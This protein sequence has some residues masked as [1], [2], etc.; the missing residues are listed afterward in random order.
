MIHDR[1]APLLC[2]VTRAVLDY[3]QDFINPHSLA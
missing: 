1:E 3:Q 2:D